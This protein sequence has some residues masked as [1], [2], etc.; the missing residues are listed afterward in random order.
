MRR[1]SCARIVIPTTKEQLSSSHRLLAGRSGVTRRLALSKLAS[2]H[3]SHNDQFQLRQLHR[4]NLTTSR[5]P[6]DPFPLVASNG[7][8]FQRRIHPAVENF[9]QPRR[10]SERE[11][12][13]VIRVTVRER[14]KADERRRGER[15]R[16]GDTRYRCSEGKTTR[17]VD[18]REREIERMEG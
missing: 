14:E 3:I 9:R 11:R 18:R 7:S 4:S 1:D 12:G 8:I 17:T 10:E 16:K 13:C 5:A 6:R 2:K 15:E